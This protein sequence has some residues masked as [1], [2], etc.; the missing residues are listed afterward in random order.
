MT[1]H[2]LVAE[3]TTHRRTRKIPM[4]AIAARMD[5]STASLSNWERGKFTPTLASLERWAETLGYDVLLA[6][7]DHPLPATRHRIV[8][9]LVEERA[10]RGVKQTV[11]AARAGVIN[12]NLCRWEKGHSIPSLASITRWAAALGYTLV[13]VPRTAS[14]VD[15][16][17][18][19]AS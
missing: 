7:D 3:L 11:V 19:V 5:A 6:K 15:A 13:L 18:A 16:V 2:P 9:A 14:T 4:E 10:T 12:V 1:L 8:P 17:G